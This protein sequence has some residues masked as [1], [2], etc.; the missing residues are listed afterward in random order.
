MVGKRGARG[1]RRRDRLAE[2]VCSL[3]CP[4]LNTRQTC[5]CPWRI[6]DAGKRCDVHD[7]VR[8][9]KDSEEIKLVLG[10]LVYESEFETLQRMILS[11][12]SWAMVLFSPRECDDSTGSHLH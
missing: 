1:L 12:C 9:A 8:N 4:P 5:E 6:R 7:S 2:L 11:V 3:V 10:L